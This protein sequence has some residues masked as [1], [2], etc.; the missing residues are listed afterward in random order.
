MIIGGFQDP[1]F[2]RQSLKTRAR[3]QVNKGG[4]ERESQ[5]LINLVNFD[6]KVDSNNTGSFD[7][8]KEHGEAFEMI[9]KRSKTYVAKNYI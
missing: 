9:R 1:T 4:Q 5:G 2:R 7:E 3:Q 8:D 6:Q